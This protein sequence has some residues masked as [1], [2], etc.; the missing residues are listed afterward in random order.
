MMEAEWV[1]RATEVK[2][3]D[4]KHKLKAAHKERET[5]SNQRAEAKAELKRLDKEK[6]DVEAR[7]K[8]KSW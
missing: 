5:P 2:I 1:K 8:E 4:L 3:N 7:L 6:A